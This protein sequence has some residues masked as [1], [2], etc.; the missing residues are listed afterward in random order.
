MHDIPRF[1]RIIND[2]RFVVSAAC[3]ASLCQQLAQACKQENCREDSS[4]L[5][6]QSHQNA[7]TCPH[8]EEEYTLS[9]WEPKLYTTGDVPAPGIS[10][11]QFTPGRCKQ[12][13]I[14]SSSNSQG[15]ASQDQGILACSCSALVLATEASTNESVTVCGP[16]GK[17][18][19]G[20]ITLAFDDPQDILSVTFQNVQAGPL[21]SFYYTTTSDD[22]VQVEIPSV[23]YANPSVLNL[24]NQEIKPQNVKEIA[25]RYTVEL[26]FIGM[27]LCKGGGSLVGDPHVRT[28]DHA[29]YTVL[30]EGN[31]LVWRFNSDTDFT[32]MS[33][34][35]KREVDW[36]IYAHYS[37]HRR[38][39]TR[40]LLLVDK[41]ARSERQRLELTSEDCKLR[42][43]E[44][45]H[46]GRI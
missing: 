14:L 3:E 27:K 22:V 46:D 17:N 11:K 45:D 32:T 15:V 13:A 39:W 4:I 10:I 7:M 26:G 41:S 43:H 16:S 9:T 35:K 31:F 19:F 8:G 33:G 42:K 44:V 38:S 23:G 34:L 37:A 24:A 20:E 21:E 12:P 2:L 29:H 18:Q 1:E 6:L 40:G 30:N 5:Q 28:Q 25:W 36:Q